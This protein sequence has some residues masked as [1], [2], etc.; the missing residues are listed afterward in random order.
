MGTIISLTVSD[1][2]LDASKNC[3]GSDH[4]VLFQKSDHVVLPE[5]FEELAKGEEPSEEQALSFT[6]LRKTLAEVA[7]RVELLGFSLDV[8]RLEYDTLVKHITQGREENIECYP[9]DYEPLGVLYTFDEFQHFLNQYSL[10]DLSSENFEIDYQYPER[11]MELI[12]NKFPQSVI[13]KIPNFDPYNYTFWSEKSAFGCIINILHPY[14]LIRL[15]SE[16]KKNRTEFVEWDYGKI[17][18]NGWVHIE[19]IKTGVRREESFLIATE[20]TS[21]AHILSKAFKQ[22]KPGV[23]DFFRF[24]DV[25]ARHPFP[26]TGGLAKFAEGLVK[27]DVQN[28]IVFVLDNDSEGVDALNKINAMILPDNMGC[29]C[30]PDLPEF[31]RFPARGPGGLAI[32]NINGQAAAIECYLDLNFGEYDTHFI[33]WTN[34]K[35]DIDSYQGSLDKKEYYARKYLNATDHK[36]INN[37][38]DTSKLE[39]LLKAVIGTCGRVAG[40]VRCDKIKNYYPNLWT[41]EKV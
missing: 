33:R 8:I 35:E 29:M 27:I 18:S 23:A 10:S 22:I 38:Y 4:G 30:L 37:E 40:R 12:K 14:S 7:D 11:N 2:M 25:K 5:Y 41:E 32:A 28:Q 21:D 16:N 6:V 34:Y 1:I 36:L 15:L 39:A 13:K 9:K 24:I 20:G 26:G 3:M 17:V 19:E 31:E